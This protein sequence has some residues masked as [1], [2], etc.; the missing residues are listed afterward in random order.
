VKVPTGVIAA[1]HFRWFGLS[2]S[3]AVEAA[4]NALQQASMMALILRLLAFDCPFITECDASSFAFGVVL[5]Q[6]EGA[7]AFLSRPI[8]PRH[9]KLVPYEHKLIGLMQVV[10]YWHPYLWAAR[11]W[12]ARITTA[13]SSSSTSSYQRHYNT[14]GPANYWAM[15]S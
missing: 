2:W 3:D 12:I 13:S 9:T 4:F 10:R 6:G 11:S 8:T 14:S 5:H 7:V 1:G 15:T